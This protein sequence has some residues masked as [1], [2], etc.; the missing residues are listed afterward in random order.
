D[1]ISLIQTVRADAT[2]I[3]V[4]IAELVDHDGKIASNATIDW[5]NTPVSE[6]LSAILPTRFE[7]D[8]RA[9]ARAEA[10]FG[11]GAGAEIFLYVTV[12][13]GISCCL[14]QNGQPYLGARGLTGTF[15]SARNVF[16]AADGML[17]NSPPL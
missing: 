8:V 11:A 1:V 5:L 9:A 17:S 6:R 13:T 12:G 14:I 2:A 4:G 16:A 15:A 7:A 3:G 10:R